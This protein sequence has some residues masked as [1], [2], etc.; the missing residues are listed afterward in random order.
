M[1][2]TS[3]RKRYPVREKPKLPPLRAAGCILP[4]P[5]GAFKIFLAA[6]AGGGED[7]GC[8]TPTSWLVAEK[9]EAPSGP[10]ASVWSDDGSSL[11]LTRRRVPERQGV[12]MARRGALAPVASRELKVTW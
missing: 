10:P 12:V 3:A 1:S 6:L 4:P 2:F 5:A 7:E 8:L 9:R 11:A